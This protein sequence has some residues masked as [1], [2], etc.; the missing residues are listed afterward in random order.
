MMMIMMIVIVMAIMMIIMMIVI[1]MAI[2]MMIM[3][4]LQS[5]YAPEK[6]ARNLNGF[7]LS[8]MVRSS[9]LTKLRPSNAI[10]TSKLLY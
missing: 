10:A 4:T 5:L 8:G 6:H 9:T 3:T 2:M 1:V 7:A